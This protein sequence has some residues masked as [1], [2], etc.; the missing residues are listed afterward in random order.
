MDP[1][2]PVDHAHQY[3]D[4]HRHYY[5]DQHH[6]HHLAGGVTGGAAPARSRVPEAH[7]SEQC[8]FESVCVAAD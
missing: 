6:H 3:P 8:P 5:A 2:P 4:Q 1:H 7:P